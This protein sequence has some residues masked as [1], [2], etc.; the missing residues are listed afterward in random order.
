MTEN[1]PLRVIDTEKSL[2]QEALDAAAPVL[3]ADGQSV[4]LPAGFVVTPEFRTFMAG[5][6][7][8]PRCPHYMPRA[9]VRAGFDC[10]EHCSLGRAA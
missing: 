10:C 8:A 2:D 5:R 4:L 7:R 1:L 9:D 6:V 3:D